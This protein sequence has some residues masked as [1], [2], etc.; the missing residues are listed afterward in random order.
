MIAALDLIWRPAAKCF[1]ATRRAPYKHPI[2]FSLTSE[3]QRQDSVRSRYLPVQTMLACPTRDNRT[4][5]SEQN[6]FHGI[7]QHMHCRSASRL[8]GTPCAFATGAEGQAIGQNTP[9][10]NF[11]TL[12]DRIK[13]CAF[14]N[15]ICERKRTNYTTAA[16]EE[17]LLINIV[18]S[19]VRYRTAQLFPRGHSRSS[20]LVGSSE[21][22]FD[23]I[24]SVLVSVL[25]GPDEQMSKSRRDLQTVPF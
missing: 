6:S 16:I 23:R 11:D 3:A 2:L 14:G 12:H 10:D 13:E 17:R 24:G 22:N 20:P 7:L 18:S 19:C 15:R 1:L 25:Q 21:I 5:A 4:F 8:H 9:A